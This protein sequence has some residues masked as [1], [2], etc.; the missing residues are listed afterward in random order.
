MKEKKWKMPKWMRRYREYICNTGGNPIEELMNDHHTTVFSNTPRALICVAVDTQI[1]LL[2]RLWKAGL[3]QERRNQRGATSIDSRPNNIRV[4]DRPPTYQ[5]DGVPPQSLCL[6]PERFVIAMVD[7]GWG[8][9]D[10]IAWA[11]QILFQDD[12]TVGSVMPASKQCG[13]NPSW[14]HLY[15]FTKSTKDIC[16]KARD[17]REWVWVR[18]EENPILYW[19][20]RET[21]ERAETNPDPEAVYGKLKLWRP[22]R[23]WMGFDSYFDLDAVRVPNTE[24]GIKHKLTHPL[25]KNPPTVWLI[26]TQPSPEKHFAQFPEALLRRPILATC[27]PQTGIVLDPFMGSGR[28]ALAALSLGRKFLGIELSQKY[29]DI[30]MRRIEREMPLLVVGGA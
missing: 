20:N 13:F 9:P 21:Q 6:I 14:E 11:K 17:T 2:T 22:V 7:D 30:A 3:L 25:G 23:K 26:A 27:P 15:R 18:P 10:R 12:T 5:P 19:V 24:S 29:I 4:T 8:V 16:W 1:I 28:T